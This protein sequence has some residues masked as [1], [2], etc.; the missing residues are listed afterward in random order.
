M[1]NYIQHGEVITY[2][3]PEGAEIVSGQIVVIGD[4]AGIAVNSGSAGDEISVKLEG[5]YTV[6]KVQTAIEQ[7]KK[8]YVNDDLKATET[9][10]GNTFLGYA[11]ETGGTG[12]TAFNVLLARGGEYIVPEEQQA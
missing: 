2:T 6:P 7:G 12:T 4:L 3:V 10:T 8:V 9:T 1:K 11:F 5:V